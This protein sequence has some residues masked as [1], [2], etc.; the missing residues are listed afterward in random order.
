[1]KTTKALRLSFALAM[2]VVV[3]HSHA[4][5]KL[6]IVIH[7]F[8][9]NG[10]PGSEKEILPL[11]GTNKKMILADFP[12]FGPNLPVL[13]KQCFGTDDRQFSN[14]PNASARVTSDFTVVVS[15][16]PKIE[17]DPAKR[18]RSGPTRKIDCTSGAVL[19]TKSSNV[20][21]CVLGAPAYG[22]GKLQVNVTCKAA[23][24][25][26]PVI[27]EKFTPDLHFGGVF[28]YDSATKSIA[29]RGDVGAF[30]SYEAYAS[31]NGSALKKVFNVAPEK[32]A[33]GQSLIDL[34]Q[35]INTKKIDVKDITL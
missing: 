25:L 28:T 3:T 29:F 6:R 18:F 26:V 14:D 22:S 19:A 15:P 32:G 31:V 8:I 20:S 21:R 9:P 2:L 5:D 17:T 35:H 16:T 24:P 7:S 30:P 34:W 11:P 1:M 13:G 10:Y 4:Q 23:D 33:G 12:I 27:P